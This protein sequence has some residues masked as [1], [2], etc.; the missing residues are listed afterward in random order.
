MLVQVG[1][2]APEAREFLEPAER[3]LP[4]ERFWRHQ[5]H[6]LAMFIGEDFFR[7]YRLPITFDEQVVVTKRFHLKPLLSLLTGNQ[8]FFILTLSQEGV[9]L[10]QGTRFEV[11]EVPMDHLPDDLRRLLTDPDLEESLMLEASARGMGRQK[12]GP[13]GVDRATRTVGGKGYGA[14]PE[15]FHGQAAAE[16]QEPKK[17]IRKYFQRIDEGL[18]ALWAGGKAA[19]LILAG[20]EYLLPLYAEANEYPHLVAQGITGSPDQWTDEELHDKAWEIVKPEF[21]ADQ[22][23]AV[24]RYKPLAAAGQQA[25]DDLQEIVRGAYFER[26]EVLFVPKGR[27]RWGSFDPE[28]GEITVHEERQ[29][30][31]EDLLD[32]AA[33][34]TLANNGNVYVIPSEQMPDAGPAAAIFRWESE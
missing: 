6:G 21:Q 31:D 11:E 19:P 24:N 5:G 29:P 32:F 17:R 26:V 34:H 9:R 25:S 3:L 1:L 15:V 4:D 2:D 8:R 13:A 7:Y 28:T 23:E 30:G 20:V 18:R 27:H 12:E 16:E 14:E 10:L 33:M 22:T